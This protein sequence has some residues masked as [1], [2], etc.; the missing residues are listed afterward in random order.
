MSL[1]TI[2]DWAGGIGGAILCLELIV[3]LLIMVAINAG[4]AFG[5]YWL[6]R[7]V[8]W[9]HE[10][11]EWGRGLVHKYVDKGANIVAAPV[12]LTSSAWSGL[13]VGLYRATHWPKTPAA[14]NKVSTQMDV[15]QPAA[16]TAGDTTRAA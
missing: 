13:K 7:K 11:I 6:L 8:G 10:K 4:L 2:N 16:K 14:G 5:L 9:A 15:A 3:L 1:D 12:I